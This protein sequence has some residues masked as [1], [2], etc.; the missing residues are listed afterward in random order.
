M[1]RLADTSV[2]LY[3]RQD[4]TVSVRLDSYLM[5]HCKGSGFRL[6]SYLNRFD[7]SL[8]LESGEV[9]KMDEYA[10]TDTCLYRM[11]HMIHEFW[12]SGQTNME[13]IED[14]AARLHIDYRLF[15]FDGQ[16][17]PDQIDMIVPVLARGIRSKRWARR[18]ESTA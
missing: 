2:S 8:T 15:S 4:W 16:G 3:R 18:S 5:I 6:S 9:V 12:G 10:Y 13:S 17:D 14:G 7:C 11:G 1:L